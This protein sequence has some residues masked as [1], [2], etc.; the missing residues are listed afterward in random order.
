MYSSILLIPGL[1]VATLGFGLLAINFLPLLGAVAMFCYYIALVCVFVVPYWA[2]KW[3][4]LRSPRGNR[5][6]AGGIAVVVTIANLTVF[7]AVNL[8]A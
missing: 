1:V 5:V 8:I 3:R 4:R 7:L 6:V 2:W